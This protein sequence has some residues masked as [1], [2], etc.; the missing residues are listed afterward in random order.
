MGK[1]RRK[2]KNKKVDK[3]DKV[4]GAKERFERMRRKRNALNLYTSDTSIVSK[5]QKYTVYSCVEVDES[6]YDLF[7]CFAFEKFLYTAKQPVRKYIIHGDIEYNKVV[8]EYMYQEVNKFY[9]VTLRKYRDIIGQTEKDI[10]VSDDD[11][12]AEKCNSEMKRLIAIKD[13]D[14]RV[15]FSKEIKIRKKLDADRREERYVERKKESNRKL[16]TY[17]REFFTHLHKDIEKKSKIKHVKDMNYI[18]KYFDSFVNLNRKTLDD[19]FNEEYKTSCHRAI[20]HWGAF[21]SIEDAKNFCTTIKD[22]ANIGQTYIHE[23]GTWQIYNP[24]GIMLEDTTYMDDKLNSVMMSYKNKEK[25]ARQE[26]L[27]RKELLKEKEMRDSGVVYKTY[28]KDDK[29]TLG[30]EVNK[31]DIDQRKFKEVPL[32]IINSEFEYYNPR[33]H[34][35]LRMK[36]EEM[37]DERGVIQGVLKDVINTEIKAGHAHAINPNMM[38]MLNM[39]EDK[40]KTV[41]KK[42]EENRNKELTYI[43]DQETEKR[44]KKLRDEGVLKEKPKKEEPKKEEPKP[45]YG[46]MR[47]DISRRRK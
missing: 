31:K 3:L 23:T 47:E 42:K 2:R 10:E 35:N 30:K 39:D 36:T 17:K 1:K 27:Y 43:N 20:K 46:F 6:V 5:K 21:K 34:F 4:V 45:K 26:I 9:E 25:Q 28:R 8:N 24:R 38:S 40:I 33:D 12:E 7:Y 16:E 22:R 13:K 41:I 44:L 29:E 15:D 37:D 11:I 32:D 19:I 18:H 14:D